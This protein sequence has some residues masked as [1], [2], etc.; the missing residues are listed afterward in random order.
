MWSEEKVKR[1][2]GG[3]GLVSG[4]VGFGELGGHSV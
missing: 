4:C 2:K 3:R 1:V